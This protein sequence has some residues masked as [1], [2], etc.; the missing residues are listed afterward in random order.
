MLPEVEMMSRKIK[1]FHEDNV[2]MHEIVR[3]FD[4]VLADKASKS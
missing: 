1:T 4:E 2:K 3:R